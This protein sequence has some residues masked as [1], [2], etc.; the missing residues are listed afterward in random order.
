M[1]VYFMP[2]ACLPRNHALQTSNR[3]KNPPPI[4]GD[5]NTPKRVGLVMRRLTASA[6]IDRRDRRDSVFEI[7][8]GGEISLQVGNGYGEILGC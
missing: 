8:R 1:Y 2:P 7:K 5:R 6:P 3:G 4:F